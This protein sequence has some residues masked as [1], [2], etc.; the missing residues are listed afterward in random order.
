[1]A[2]ATA[3]DLNNPN[4]IAKRTF[5]ERK[6]L[7]HDGMSWFST[8]KEALKAYK[9]SVAANNNSHMKNIRSYMDA[10]KLNNELISDLESQL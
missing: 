9:A 5:I 3:W 7:R 6:D 8:K 4:G 2:W 10:I 1:M